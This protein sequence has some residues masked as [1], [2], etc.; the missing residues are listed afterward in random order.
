MTTTKLAVAR[1]TVSTEKLALLY[2]GAACGLMIGYFFLINAL[3]LQ[4]Y[5]AARFGS[6]AFTVLAAFF[7]LRAFKAQS[8]SPAPY[9]PGLSLGFL[10][11]LVAS[12]LFAGFL[13]V[14]AN[15]LNTRY[16]DELQNQTYFNGSVGA[17]MLAASITLLGV[18]IGSLTGYILMMSEDTDGED[19]EGEGLNSLD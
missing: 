17:Y 11:G 14:Y 3:G 12:V 16:L 10:V 7:A 6:H 9:M 5:E 8:T 15:A 1:S 4:H 2:G 13:F 19:K 18:V